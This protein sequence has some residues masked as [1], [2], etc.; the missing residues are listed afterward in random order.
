MWAEPAM[1]QDLQRCTEFLGS[2]GRG[3]LDPKKLCML[4]VCVFVCVCVEM[5]SHRGSLELLASTE[6]C[7]YVFNVG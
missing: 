6:S 5:K 3:I 4:C 1:Q 7:M 2:K